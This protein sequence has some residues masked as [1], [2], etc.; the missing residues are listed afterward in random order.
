MSE[1]EPIIQK[2]R[3]TIERL[4]KEPVSMGEFARMF[5]E[6]TG[7]EYTFDYYPKVLEMKEKGEWLYE[8]VKCTDTVDIDDETYAVVRAV[9]EW[10]INFEAQE[11]IV[12]R[13]QIEEIKKNR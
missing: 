1:T 8:T 13:I 2:I 11:W 12:A 9:E 10:A 6:E 3:E 5:K 7:W 4:A